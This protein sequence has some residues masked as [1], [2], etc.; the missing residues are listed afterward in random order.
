M[1]L[2]MNIGISV[3]KKPYKNGILLAATRNFTFALGAMI[4]VKA[5]DI[6]LSNA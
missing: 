6:L 5:L 4:G 1:P 2:L 3:H